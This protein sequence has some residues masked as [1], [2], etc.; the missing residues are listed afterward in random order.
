MTKL[1]RKLKG[2]D[3]TLP[4]IVKIMVFIVVKIMGFPIVTYNL[5]SGP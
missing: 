3:N 2:K 1:D 5:R 4:T